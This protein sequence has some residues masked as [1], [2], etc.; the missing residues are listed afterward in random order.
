[1]DGILAEIF[2]SAD[3]VAFEALLSLLTSIWGEEDV[4]KEIRNA[5]FISL[6]KN[7]GSQTH[8]GSYRGISLLSIAGKI[9]PW[10]ILNCLITSISEEN[11]S[12]AQCGFRPNCSTTDMVF[13]VHQV[14]E[15]YIEQN[16][17]LVVVFI[18]L[19]KAFDMV[20]R[21]ALWVILSKLGCLTKSVNLICQFR[22]DMT[23][24][25]L[26]DGEASEPFSI[27]NGVKQGCVLAPILFNL[28][29]IC[30]LNH[31]IRYLQQEGCVLAPVLYNLFFICMLNHA[32]RDFEQGVYLRYWLDGSLFDLCRLRAKTKTEKD[33]CESTVW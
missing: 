19:T 13:S 11:L 18:D 5:T 10:V 28:F 16:M 23:V 4:P 12:E 8:C 20:S 29:F 14:Q 26:S 33:S 32:I 27:S 30:M 17:D 6:F 2:K 31:A 9:L 24:Q 15:K 7:R 22:D 3:P 1:M 25:V 21:E